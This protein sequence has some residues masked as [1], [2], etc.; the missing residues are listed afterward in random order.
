MNTDLRRRLNVSNVIDGTDNCTMS[1]LQHV[2]GVAMKYPEWFY[3]KPCTCMLTA[4]REGSC[5]LTEIQKRY[6]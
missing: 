3:C 1:R 2:R 6:W 5:A 4:Y